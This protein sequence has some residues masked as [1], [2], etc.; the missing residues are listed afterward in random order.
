MRSGSGLVYLM[1]ALVFGLS[2]AHVLIMPVEQLIVRQ[3]REMG[4]T[5]PEAINK[6]IIDI[7]RPVIQFVFGQ[8]TLDEI[9]QES[10]ALQGGFG[11][12]DGEPENAAGGGKKAAGLDPWVTFLLEERPALLSAI[13]M[14]LIFGMPYA[15]SLL[16]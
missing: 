8:K 11:D 4:K 15:I 14:L 16:G 7:G 1:I 9:G 13:F 5:D 12:N 2:M 3:K 6:T 10:L